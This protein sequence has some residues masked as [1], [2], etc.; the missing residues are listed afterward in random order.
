VIHFLNV[1]QKA[2][3]EKW[4]SARSM[5]EPDSDIC[6]HLGEAPTILLFTLRWRGGP[7]TPEFVMGEWREPN[8]VSA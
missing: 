5:T 1:P 6:N 4:S 3:I 7:T 2:V 8:F